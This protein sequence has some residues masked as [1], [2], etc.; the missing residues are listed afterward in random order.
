[1]CLYPIKL[2]KCVYFHE[3]ELKCKMLK[4]VNSWYRD[5]GTTELVEV[6]CGK[7]IECLSARA[8]EWTG[9]I[10]AEAS[11]YHDNCFLTLTYSENPV[12]LIKS[13]LQKFI[14]KMR[15]FVYP[16]KIRY[17]AC[18]EYGSKG[19]R[20]HYH[21][22]VFNWKPN[23]LEFFYKSGDNNIFKSEIV[24]RLW[25]KGFITVGDLS[26]TSAKYCCKYLQKLNLKQ[27]DIDPFLIM[28]NRPGIGLEYFKKNLKCLE[29]DGL[30]FEGT[31]YM[32][33]R[34]FLDY[35]K[36]V[37]NF[38]DFQLKNRRLLRFLIK[39]CNVNDLKAKR[40]N[41]ASKFGILKAPKHYHVYGIHEGG[42]EHE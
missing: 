7:C 18:G 20:P 39:E 11:L 30:Y 24:S 15:K 16:K 8:N 26:G 27:H 1:M 28:S 5:H 22:I 14:K 2:Y 34:Y 3:G 9:R 29:T 13:D 23:D 42:K 4:E 41:L 32:V 12:D 21:L 19:N 37:L 10:L 17:F 36:H 38:N 40:L 31:K 35:A 33:P 6:K 25:N